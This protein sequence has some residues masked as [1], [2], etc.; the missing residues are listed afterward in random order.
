MRYFLFVLLFVFSTHS[1]SGE[2]DGKNLICDWNK[3]TSEGRDNKFG[4]EFYNNVVKTWYLVK[5]Y[6]EGG[7]FAQTSYYH[8]D[9]YSSDASYIKWDTLTL[10]RKTLQ[11]TDEN[12]Q[13][14]SNFATCKVVSETDLFAQLRFRK[15]ELNKAVSKEREGNK[16]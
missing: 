6:Q 11:L 7:F 1:F 14:K 9:T 4:Y 3:P 16:I 8:K 13:N 12:M 15:E 2:I 10:D 5:N